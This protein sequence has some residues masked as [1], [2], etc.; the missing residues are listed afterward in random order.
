MPRE[1]PQ[2]V[3]WRETI[4]DA[5]ALPSAVRVRE[6]GERKRRGKGRRDRGGERNRY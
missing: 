1:V 6:G 2:H 4:D 3:L 5:P